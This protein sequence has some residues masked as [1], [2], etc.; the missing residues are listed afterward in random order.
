M[1]RIN[2]IQRIQNMYQEIKESF[3]G[4]QSN[5]VPERYKSNFVNLGGAF[6]ANYIIWKLLQRE[7]ITGKVLIVGAFGGRETYGL[8]LRGYDLY[9][10]D[11]ARVPDIYNLV[12]ANVEDSLPFNNETFDAVI[13]GE[14]IEH[15]KYD[16]R[17]LDNIMKVLKNNGVLIVT[18]PFFS[19]EQEDHL[20]IHSRITCSRLLEL[21]GFEVLCIVERPAILRIPAWINWLHHLVGWLFLKITGKLTHKFL[22]PVWA[23]MEYKIGQRYNPIRKLSKVYGGYY[24]CKKRDTITYNYLALNIKNYGVEY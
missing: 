22:L 4:A 17:S 5:F 14:V 12:I 15:L 23:D 16:A 6:E 9:N 8:L 2:K 21:C 10:V 7:I 20:R 18:V 19:D 11:I 24:L 3:L 13:I 1:L